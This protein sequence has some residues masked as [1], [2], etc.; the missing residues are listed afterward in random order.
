MGISM[1]GGLFESNLLLLKKPRVFMLHTYMKYGNKYGYLIQLAVLLVPLVLAL[2]EM[3][4][5]EM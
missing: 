4:N 3:L 5:Q 1:N 2:V